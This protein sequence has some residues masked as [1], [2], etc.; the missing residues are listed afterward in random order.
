MIS[1]PLRTSSLSVYEWDLT[2]TWCFDTNSLYI[3]A[4]YS[5]GVVDSVALHKFIHLYCTQQRTCPNGISKTASFIYLFINF[6]TSFL[7]SIQLFR[8]MLSRSDIFHPCTLLLSHFFVIYKILIGLILFLTILLPSY[9]FFFCVR[10][11]IITC[12][13]ILSFFRLFF[14]LTHFSRHFFK[15][16]SSII[17]F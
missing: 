1:L 16:V 9:L 12:E 7:P 6:L 11:I 2:K 13:M 10:L 3:V 4:S 14:L 8:V 5:T 17:I 15:K